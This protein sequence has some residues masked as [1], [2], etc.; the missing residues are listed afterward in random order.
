MAELFKEI[1]PSILQT[2][3]NVL[4]DPKDYVAYLVNKALSYHYDCILYANQMNQ[5]PNLDNDMQYQYYLNKVRSYKRP[6][7]KWHKFEKNEAIEAIKEYYG[8]SN[9]KARATLEVLSDVQVEDIK[10]R[11]YKG[12]LN[13]RSNKFGGGNAKR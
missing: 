5:L 2:K 1:I 11:L 6:F 9:D 4:D 12:G 8:Y 3:R 10:K 13:D 7:Q